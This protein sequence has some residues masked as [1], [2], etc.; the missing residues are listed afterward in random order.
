MSEKK[1]KYVR[2]GA[3]RVFRS[4]V[5]GAWY[6]VTAYWDYGNG[7]YIA[8]VKREVHPDDLREL[9]TLYQIAQ[10]AQTDR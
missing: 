8:S 5:T 10:H 4:P 7:H 9:E 6:V 1:G 3:P 2:G